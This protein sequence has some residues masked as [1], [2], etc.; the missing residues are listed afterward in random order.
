MK[1]EIDDYFLLWNVLFHPFLIILAHTEDLGSGAP[2]IE[3]PYLSH[4]N[5][6]PGTELISMTDYYSGVLDL[7]KGKKKM[8]H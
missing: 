8:K 3:Y 5:Q 1:S 6:Q 7:L 2:H 4:Q